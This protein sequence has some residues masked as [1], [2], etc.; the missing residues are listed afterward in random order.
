ML[1]LCL[2]MRSL[3]AWDSVPLFFYTLPVFVELNLIQFSIIEKANRFYTAIT[4]SNNIYSKIM[5]H[6]MKENH[7]KYIKIL[8][9]YIYRIY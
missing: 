9:E 6:I 1:N 4:T 5:R 2:A 8:N 3:F 7:V